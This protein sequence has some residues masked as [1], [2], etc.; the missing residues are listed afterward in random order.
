MQKIRAILLA[1]GDFKDCESLT[2]YCRLITK[3]KQNTNLTIQIQ[4]HHI[5]P[6]AWYKLH[7]KKVDNSAS[8]TVLLSVADHAKAHLFLFQA[9]TNPEVRAQNAAAVRYM[10]DIFSE[11]LIDEYAEELNKVNIEL[12]KKKSKAL[13][14]R[15][16]AGLN[17]RRRPVICIETGQVFKTIKEAQEITGLWLKPVLSG[18]RESADGYHF[19]YYVEE[20]AKME[21]QKAKSTKPV[22]FTET[23]LV[24]LKQQYPKVGAHIPELLKT[25]SAQSIRSKALYLGI[26]CENS[27][28]RRKYNNQQII[29]VETQQTFRNVYEAGAL[30]T[31]STP[32]KLILNVCKGKSKLAYGYHWCWLEDTE[33]QAQI[34]A[35]LES[36]KIVCVETNMVY[37][38][39][40]AA[41]RD[42]GVNPSSIY[43]AIKK[44]TKAPNLHWAYAE[45]TESIRFIKEHYLTTD[46]VYTN[47]TFKPKSV[48]CVETGIVYSNMTVA[49][50]A[51]GMHGPSH[52]STA[53]K[54]GKK[55][56]GYHW[57]YV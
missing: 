48:R 8:N 24:L 4:K 18:Q 2:K 13:A 39:V 19:K 25:H 57:E 40:S 20:L 5:L 10:C 23:E 11:E 32:S 26:A 46:S 42:T 6:R 12:A 43:S 41:S 7:N 31:G 38:S 22:Y 27:T 21:T 56:G 53:C 36:K 35:G 52:I 15:R 3:N 34:I 51:L 14:E 17:E 44:P 9:A 47:Y 37:D 1:T 30:F 49:A 54:T 45:D 16:A 50:A 55:A 28:Y 29:C 33:R